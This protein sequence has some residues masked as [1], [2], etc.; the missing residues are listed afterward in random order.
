MLF[1]R[2]PF[3]FSSHPRRRGRG[4]PAEPPLPGPLQKPPQPLPA[5]PRCEMC[6]KERAPT[7]D[8][9]FSRADLALQGP[10]LALF[11]PAR[12]PQPCPGAGSGQSQA[13]GAHQ[14]RA[15]AARGEPGG[16]GRG[17]PA[18]ERGTHGNRAAAGT[19]GPAP[20]P[21][22]FAFFVAVKFLNHPK[23]GRKKKKGGGELHKYLF[24]T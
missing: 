13:P 11:P 3:A 17:G 10:D 12:L 18:T 24:L 19:E 5:L 7:G 15:R 4:K 2:A 6:C 1:S 23:G 8:H 14:G 16:E 21:R 9:F 22:G 20:L